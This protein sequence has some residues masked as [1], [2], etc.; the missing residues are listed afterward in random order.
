[1]ITSKENSSFEQ[2]PTTPKKSQ[3]LSKKSKLVL[4]LTEIFGVEKDETGK[5][6]YKEPTIIGHLILVGSQ[7]A[8][9]SFAYAASVIFANVKANNWMQELQNFNSNKITYL[10]SYQENS[11]AKKTIKTSKPETS[12]KIIIKESER[13]RIIQQFEEIQARAV[14]HYNIM[15][16]FYK[17]KYIATS[18]ALKLASVSVLCLIFISCLGWGRVHKSVINVFVITT[19]FA[20]FY[21]DIAN[22]YKHR[23]NIVVNEA[24]YEYYVDLGNYIIS[25]LTT[26]TDIEGT[27]EEPKKFIH[28]VDLIMEQVN[29]IS[30]VFDNKIIERRLQSVKSLI[31]D[32]DKQQSSKKMEN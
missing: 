4:L 27:E 26:K 7:F 32:I 10:T 18:M 12:K 28:K 22:V 31:P 8:L 11:I 24:K 2:Q 19:V 1:M 30:L 25:Y 17:T 16:D 20:I 21:G 23:E 3:A 6:K 13:R 15:I 14:M 5:E 9:I 29:D